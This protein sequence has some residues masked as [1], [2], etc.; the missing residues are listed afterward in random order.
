MDLKENGQYVVIERCAALPRRRSR[1]HIR[2]IVSRLHC[3]VHCTLNSVQCTVHCIYSVLYVPEAKRKAH[4]NWELIPGSNTSD[5]RYL[6]SPRAILALCS[7]VVHS[8]WRRHTQATLHFCT[9]RQSSSAL[10]GI[11]TEGR[12]KKSGR[13]GSMVKRKF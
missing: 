6:D 10:Y 11:E 4:C 13:G 3:T 2:S 7:I 1:S 5:W 9:T 12:L 8:F